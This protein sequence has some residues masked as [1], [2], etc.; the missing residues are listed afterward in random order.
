MKNDIIINLSGDG[1]EPF[2][3]I[4]YSF[5]EFIAIINILHPFIRYSMQNILPLMFIRGL[6]KHKKGPKDIKSFPNPFT[7]EMTSMSTQVKSIR[8]WN[9]K[10]EIVNVHLQNNIGP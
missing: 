10:D 7:D 6:P 5:W 4:T 1:V 3:S 8:L 9:G 2:K